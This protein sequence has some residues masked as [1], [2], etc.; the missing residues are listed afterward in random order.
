MFCTINLFNYTHTHTITSGRHRSTYIKPV[1]HFVIKAEDIA[2]VLLDIL[3][4]TLDIGS[5]QIRTLVAV[6]AIF[7]D[8]RH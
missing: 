7:Q 3:G 1:V 6:A 2:Y 8:G 5:S 4:T